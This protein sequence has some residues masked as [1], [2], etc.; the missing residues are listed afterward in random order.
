M[1]TLFENK[2]TY[3]VGVLSDT[4]GFLPPK[5]LKT[6]KDTDLIIHAGDIGEPEILKALEAIAPVVAVRG[7]MDGGGWNKRL[8]GSEIVEIGATRLYVLHNVHE[9]DFDPAAA[10]FNA[11]IYGHFHRPELT[12][13]NGVLFL[14]PGSTSWPR[15]GQ[16]A[17]I[18]LLHIHEKKL[19]VHL[20]EIDRV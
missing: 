14:N 15:N 20:I 10:G 4:H 1:Q 18:A 13:Q 7:N 19:D 16:S 12:K 8:H 2:D 9:L 17:S 11:V 5:V 3:L 6:F